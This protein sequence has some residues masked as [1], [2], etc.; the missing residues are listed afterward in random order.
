MNST[1]KIIFSGPVGSGKTTA[2]NTISD[3]PTIK[4]E[5]SAS[6]EIKQL[7]ENTTVALDYGAII[8]KDDTRIHLY[9]TPGQKRF[10]FMWEIL[11]IGGIGLLLLVD[12]SDKNALDNLKFFLN[13]FK[14]FI[15]RT[16]V[17]VG[18]T[19]Q[20]INKRYDLSEYHA[21]FDKELPVIPIFEIDSRNRKDIELMV[22]TLLYTLDPKLSF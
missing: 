11:T 8:L 20:D 3:I 10:D 12:G 2:I 22:E 21:L 4:T 7:K 19:K 16:S 1:Y 6:D 14:K 15:N 9:G 5:A 18:I 17:V 13:S